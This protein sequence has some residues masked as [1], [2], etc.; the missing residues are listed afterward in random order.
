M[1][2][3]VDALTA[4][5]PRR[6]GAYAFGLGGLAA[7]AMP[8]AGLFPALF[9]AYPGLILLIRAAENWRQ[10]FAA[11]WLFGFGFH[12]VGLYWISFALFT[13]I[14]QFWW[15]LPFSAAG[16]PVVLACYAGLAAVALRWLRPG[17]LAAPLAFAVV[18]TLAEWLRGWAFTGFPWN[19]PAYAWEHVPAMRQSLALGGAYGLSFVTA[20]LAAAPVLVTTAWK[21]APR[22][23]LT[24]L[25]AGGLLAAGLVGWGALRLADAADDPVPGVRL[26]LVQPDIPQRVKS[27]PGERRANF[28]NQL[29]LTASPSDDP[30]TVV[31]WAETAA[32]F[33]LVREPQAR[34]MIAAALPEGATAALIG[35]PS[36]GP[37][38]VPG[39]PRNFHNSMAA[40]DQDGGVVAQYDKHHLVPFGE[41]M[42]LRRFLPVGAI[43]GDGGEYAPGP[44]PR[45][46][47]APGVPPFS[48]L[49]CYEAIFPGEVVDDA[50]RPDWL[51]NLTNDA[52]Y[53]HSAGPHQHLAI[54]S[55]RA[56]EE[57]LP[58]VRVANTGISAVVDSYGRIT[59]SL[60]LGTRGALDADLPRPTETQTPFSRL[61]NGPLG[62]ILACFAGFL[63]FRR[64][65]R[66]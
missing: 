3:R 46:L 63:V 58:L 2:D 62:V 59:A 35:A 54:A 20:L 65:M 25:A 33:F 29:E 32:P 37:P 36:P 41:Y 1:L 56:I 52:W 43:A 48:P 51:F 14:A 17:P 30:P 7:L 55:A 16:L 64:I 42:P 26:R 31:L 47:R 45:T 9:I 8:P 5:A 18:W 21:T 11:G 39:Q 60:P 50:D 13:D 6:R 15:A 19:L 38:A 66:N 22:R 44:G 61:R 40:L 27:A 10:A 4:V 12:L 57:G 53:G 24:A 49:I 23:V 34:S 28:V